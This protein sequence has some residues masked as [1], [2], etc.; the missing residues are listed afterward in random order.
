MAVRCLS[1]G[2]M[3]GRDGRAGAA[4]RGA[5]SP[6]WPAAGL[7]LLWQ[8]A[9]ARA[10]H[11][12]ADHGGGRQV[13]PGQ[14]WP[15]ATAR[16]SG[17]GGTGGAGACAP[18]RP[19]PG[20]AVTAWCRYAIQVPGYAG[21]CAPLCARLTSAR[22]GRLARHGAAVACCQGQLARGQ[23][24]DRPGKAGRRV[25]LALGRSRPAPAHRQGTGARPAC[26]AGCLIAA[27]PP[28]PCSPSR[29]WAGPGHGHAQPPAGRRA[30]PRIRPP[31]AG[32]DIPG[33]PAQAAAAGF[34]SSEVF[35]GAGVKKDPENRISLVSA[36]K[37]R[38]AGPAAC[39]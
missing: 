24:H 22:G 3:R 13:A 26:R 1:R 12:G 33:T 2:G 27:H 20:E 5:R 4:V 7:P 34:F 28:G 14:P 17:T 19:R 8:A 25:S 37:R 30:H 10:R 39:E 23:H 35:S 38:H 31:G 6:P 32:D 21:L 9:S 36:E 29:C 16:R 18:G 15:D 11:A